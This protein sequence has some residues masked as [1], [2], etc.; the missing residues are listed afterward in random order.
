MAIDHPDWSPC[1]HCGVPLQVT[2]FPALLGVTEPG[3]TGEKLV[4]DDQSSCFYHPGKKAA[5]AC[6]SCGRFL[7]ALC[8]LELNTAHIC[9]RCLEKGMKGGRREDLQNE[10]F[11]YDGL[12]L[13]LATYPLLIF[14]LTLFTAPMALFVVARY[15]KK[16]GGPTPRTRIRFVFAAGLSGLQIAGW[17][18]LLYVL[19]TR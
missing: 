15:W 17:T 2:T 7:C 13:A 12:A 10:R 5:I 6:E 8:D 11:L 9:P 1:P 18:A 14:W 16:P 19:I 4:V 3:R